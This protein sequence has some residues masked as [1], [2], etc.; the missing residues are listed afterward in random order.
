MNILKALLLLVMTF[1]INNVKAND[2]NSNENSRT[3]YGL[4]YSTSFSSGSTVADSSVFGALD[5]K[6]NTRYGFY[7]LHKI[8]FLKDVHTKVAFSKIVSEEDFFQ[9][10]KLERFSVDLLLVKRIV[11]ELGLYLG[12]GATYHIN[13]VYEYTYDD[14]TFERVNYD[15]SLGYILEI[16]QIYRFGLEVGFT[17][18]AIN[19]SGTKDSG[20]ANLINLKENIDAS[21]ISVNFA[22]NF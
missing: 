17:Y 10:E 15:N 22:I 7:M 19:Y 12:M 8:N 2:D 5:A 13:P 4:Q 1:T 6:E 3:V 9:D 11:P 20:N 18:T 14:N 16:K 21:N